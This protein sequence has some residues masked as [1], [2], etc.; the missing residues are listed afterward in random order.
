[1]I[2]LYWYVAEKVVRDL[3]NKLYEKLQHLNA[4]FYS[5]ARTGDL[6]SRVTT[7]IQIIRNFFAFGIE[8][9]IRAIL[10]VITVFVIMVMQNWKLALVYTYITVI[11]S[12]IAIA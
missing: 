6:M 7:D 11:Y 4:S 2:R 5:K 12:R 9:R 1:M 8:H 10:I 3:R